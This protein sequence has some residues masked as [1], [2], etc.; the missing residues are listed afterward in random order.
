MVSLVIVMRKE[1]NGM[2]IERRWKSIAL[3]ELMEKI[4]DYIF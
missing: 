3:E 1:M 2:V 4:Q